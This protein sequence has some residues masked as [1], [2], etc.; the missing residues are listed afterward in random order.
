MSLNGDGGIIINIRY[1][2]NSVLRTLLDNFRESEGRKRDEGCSVVCEDREG[3]S[4]R[5]EKR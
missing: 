2:R 5:P 4:C 1:R 3:D